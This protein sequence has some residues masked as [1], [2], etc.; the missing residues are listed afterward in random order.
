MK[1]WRMLQKIGF[2]GNRDLPS[3]AADLCEELTALLDLACYAA[4]GAVA[5]SRELE[6]QWN[7]LNTA[8]EQCDLIARE[9]QAVENRIAALRKTIESLHILLKSARARQALNGPQRDWE[10][11]NRMLAELLS[12]RDVLE[13]KETLENL[14]PERAGGAP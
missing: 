2:G 6:R 1:F 7:E 9:F 12:S 11:S 14:E 10:L 4:A 5:F 3:Q 8:G 13:L